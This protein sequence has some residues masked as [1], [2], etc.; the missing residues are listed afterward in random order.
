[1]S[2]VFK[3]CKIIF[4]LRKLLKTNFF[5]ELQSTEIMSL[6]TL[7]HNVKINEK[8]CFRLIILVKVCLL[9]SKMFL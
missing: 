5:S 6:L 7:L 1:M 9:I 4:S 3:I 2:P 8:I